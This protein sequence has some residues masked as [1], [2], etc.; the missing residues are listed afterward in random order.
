MSANG[1]QLGTR[2]PWRCCTRLRVG[3][4]ATVCPEQS[5][6]PLVHHRVR[7]NVPLAVAS[8]GA[9]TRFA[10]RDHLPADRL[11]DRR[12]ARRPAWPA[13][14]AL[15]HCLGC[16]RER[17]PI[18]RS[19]FATPEQAGVPGRRRRRRR[20][21]AFYGGPGRPRPLRYRARATGLRGLSVALAA[22][23][24]TR[25]LR[26]PKL[27]CQSGRP[28]LGS[29]RAR[30]RTPASAGYPSQSSTGRDILS[31]CRSRSTTAPAV[32]CQGQS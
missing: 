32:S 20:S 18:A 11:L 9:D 4:R 8:A 6:R 28:A 2:T 7:G 31:R 17:A 13:S 12:G 22:A 3:R 24:H 29:S 19:T 15:S 23:R 30:L 26:S 14:T 10:R 27:Q 21:T 5:S 1:S 16:S 25:M